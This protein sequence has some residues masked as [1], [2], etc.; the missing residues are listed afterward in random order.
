MHEAIES[1]ARREKC[2]SEKIEM[3]EDGGLSPSGGGLACCVRRAGGGKRGLHHRSDAVA[4]GR[5][6]ELS[7][8]R[9]FCETRDIGVPIA[10]PSQTVAEVRSVAD[11]VVPGARIRRGLYYRY[12]L[13]WTKR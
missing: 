9:E 2:A 1:R 12:L 13:R 3:R 11:A 5:R 7:E 6:Q 8:T 10:A 4:K